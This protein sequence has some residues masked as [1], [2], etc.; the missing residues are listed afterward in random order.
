MCG[1]SNVHQTHLYQPE[2]ASHALESKILLLAQID[3]IHSP[4]QAGMFAA[5]LYVAVPTITKSSYPSPTGTHHADA[6]VVRIGIAASSRRHTYTPGL[7]DRMNEAEHPRVCALE[8]R[9]PAAKPKT[10]GT[11]IPEPAGEPNTAVRRSPLP[12]HVPRYYVCLCRSMY[13]VCIYVVDIA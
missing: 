11:Y 2:S 13:F 12:S 6:V 7:R 8:G 1:R 4:G 10:A 9:Q 3:Y 5:F